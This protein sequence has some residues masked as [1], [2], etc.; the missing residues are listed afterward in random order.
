MYGVVAYFNAKTLTEMPLTLVT[1]MVYT[2]IVYFGMGFTVTADQFFTFYFAL[3]A[4]VECSMSLGY[5]VSSIF[6]NYATA[7]MVAPMLMMPFM[8]FSG[9]YSNLHTIPNWLAWVQWTSP[10]RYALEA[11]ISNEYRT[12]E[13]DTFDICEALNFKLGTWPSIGIML[14]IAY[15]CR[16]LAAIGLKSLITR[17]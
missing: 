1:P 15:L 11:M 13:P 7:S 17:F 9:F 8:L 16:I 2:I 12:V 6:H 4:L 5:M 14:G 3:W 10:I